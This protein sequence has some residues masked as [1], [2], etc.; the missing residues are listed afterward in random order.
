MSMKT[1]AFMISPTSPAVAKLP[2][3]VRVMIREQMFHPAKPA[4]MPESRTDHDVDFV[5]RDAL[6]YSDPFHDG[7]QL[8]CNTVDPDFDLDGSQEF[9]DSTEDDNLHGLTIVE[10]GYGNIRRWLRGRD[11]L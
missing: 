9:A 2:R 8:N 10:P 4:P 7:H 5:V 6:A 3:R 11:I 1:A